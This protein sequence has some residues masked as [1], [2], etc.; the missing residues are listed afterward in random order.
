MS[1]ILQALRMS[2]LRDARPPLDI[3]RHKR[4]HDRISV[5]R[6]N[7]YKQQKSKDVHLKGDSGHESYKCDSAATSRE[8]K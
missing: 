2:Q 4:L 8:F 3:V 5:V 7:G 1:S 6:L